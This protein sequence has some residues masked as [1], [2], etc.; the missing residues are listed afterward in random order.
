MGEKIVPEE[1]PAKEHVRDDEDGR[2]DGLQGDS[3]L[4]AFFRQPPDWYIKQ[5][6]H[7]AREGASERLLKPLASSVACEV[8]GSAARWQEVL[9]YIETALKERSRA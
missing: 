2:D 6:K 4:L 8:F 5:A 1:S 9:A 3:A 7:C